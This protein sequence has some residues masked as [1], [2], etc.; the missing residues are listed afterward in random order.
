MFVV[1]TYREA[2][3]GNHTASLELAEAGVNPACSGRVIHY[4]Y[5]RECMVAT[6]T[7]VMRADLE[8]VLAAK[9]TMPFPVQEGLPL[10]GE[11]HHLPSW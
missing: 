7:S 8:G 6:G 4:L 2:R 3:I 9:A 10:V 11:Q 1:L 5:I